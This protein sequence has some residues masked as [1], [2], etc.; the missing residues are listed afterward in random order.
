MDLNETSRTCKSNQGRWILTKKTNLDG[1][2]RY[3]AR[4]VAKGYS[5]ILGIDYQETYSSVLAITSFRLLV[6]IAVNSGWQVHQKDFRTAYLN[7]PLLTPIYIEQPEGFVKQGNDHKVCLLNKALYGLKQAGRAWQ[8]ALFNL[9]KNQDYHQ[10]QKEPCIWYKNKNEKITIIGIYVDDTLITGDD[11]KEIEKITKTMEK[12]FKMKDMG[13]LQE[14]LGIQATYTKTGIKLNQSNYTKKLIKKYGQ[15][16]CKHEKIPMPKAY[17]PD[18]Q[19]EFKDNYPIREAIGGLMYLANT[20]RPDIAFAVNNVSRHVTRPTKSL[21]IAIQKIIKYLKSTSTKGITYTQGTFEI[22]CWA[23][24]DYANDKEDR[25][26]ITGWIIKV[27]DNTVSWKSKKQA[28]VALSTTEAEYMAAS[29]AVKEIIWT[30]D[31]LFELNMIEKKLA[32]LYQDNQGAIFLE[33]NN[34]NTQRTKHIDV[35]YHFIRQAIHDGRIEIQYCPTEAMIADIFTKP[36]PPPTFERHRDS[37][38]NDDKTENEENCATGALSPNTSATHRCR[39]EG[40][41]QGRYVTTPL[42]N[43]PKGTCPATLP[44]AT[45]P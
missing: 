21:W 33:K 32:V 3:K 39:N 25:K 34:S 40:A 30:Q 15:E 26:S 35:R 1:T 27:G 29:D 6:L 9:I 10:S 5:Q 8:E 45:R 31:L 41:C 22:K 4:F 36:L 38:L 17:E 7:A 23:D 37:L 24:S 43:L 19:V 20:T 28:S 42:T 2:I 12:N 18:P 44:E 13:K 16:N 14:F 11:E